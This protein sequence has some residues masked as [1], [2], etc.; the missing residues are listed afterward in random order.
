MTAVN[1]ISNYHDNANA[2]NFLST[3]NAKKFRK[4]RGRN[5]VDLGDPKRTN[6]IMA[7]VRNYLEVPFFGAAI[8]AIL[9]IGERNLF[10]SQVRHQTEP[11]ANI[12]QWGPIVGTGIAVAGSGYVL[13]AQA[14]V[15]E[16]EMTQ[17]PAKGEIVRRVARKIITFSD[18]IGIPRDDRFDTGEEFR[19]VRSR[20]YPTVPGE[21]NRLGLRDLARVRSGYD[22]RPGDTS[23]QDAIRNSR[24]RSRAGSFRSS[25][26]GAAME[27]ETTPTPV[28]APSRRRPTLEVPSSQPGVRHVR[29]FSA[30]SQ[31]ST[32]SGAHEP[33]VIRVT[34]MEET[35]SPDHSP[36]EETTDTLPEIP[37]A[38]VHR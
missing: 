36:T 31:M 6:K 37:P 34:S 11:L 7:F 25:T 5:N 8:L 14:V 12:G 28:E 16:R 15:D 24:S 33:P 38:A 32:G 20:L 22:Q 19:E 10:S 30:G 3:D 17:P 4:F 27:G 2:C 35:A 9:V 18:W 13:I 29:T 23:P 26:S 1:R 21:E